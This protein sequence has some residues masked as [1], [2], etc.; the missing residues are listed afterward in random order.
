MRIRYLSHAFHSLINQSSGRQSLNDSTEVK[1]QLKQ[2]LKENER[3]ASRYES[4]TR[5][6]QVSTI[7]HFSATSDDASV[8]FAI[9]LRQ[10]ARRVR[11]SSGKEQETP[12][13]FES[14]HF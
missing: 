13:G 8:E 3:L 1:D 4:S 9:E 6:Y 7:Y 11:K 5:N 2:A 14:F 12:T 10:I